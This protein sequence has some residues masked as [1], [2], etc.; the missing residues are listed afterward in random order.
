MHQP[1]FLLVPLTTTFSKPAFT[2][3]S[4]TRGIV[5]RFPFSYFRLQRHI[6]VRYG[7][8]ECHTLLP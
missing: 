7:S 8:F 4:L 5:Q 2:T 3:S 6:T 1:N